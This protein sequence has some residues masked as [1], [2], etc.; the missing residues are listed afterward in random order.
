MPIPVYFHSSRVMCIWLKLFRDDIKVTSC[1]S[2][3]PR[4]SMNSGVTTSNIA[5]HLHFM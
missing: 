4:T 5:K 3:A 2:T 1:H